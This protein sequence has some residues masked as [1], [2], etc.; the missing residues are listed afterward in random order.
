MWYALNMIKRQAKD[1]LKEYS[2]EFSVVYVNGPRQS[3]KTTLVRQVFPK[4]PYVLLED[5]DTRDIA[6]SDPR[7]FLERYPQG[8]IFDE[9]QECPQLLSYMLGIVD[10]KKKKG[11]F[12][13]T[14]SQNILMLD[15]VKQSLAGRMAILD[16]LPL[17]L[18]ELKSRIRGLSVKELIYRGGYPRIWNEKV[19]PSLQM[20]QYVKTYIERDVRE[21]VNV[22]SLSLFRKFLILCAGRVGYPINKTSICNDLGV[23]DVTVQE[24]LSVLEASN[25]IFMLQ[26]YYENINKRILKTPKLYFVDTAL[27]C[28]L[29][30][31]NQASQVASHPHYGNLFENLIISEF[32]KQSVLDAAHMHS[33]YFF[34]DKSGNEVDLIQEIGNNLQVIE[35]KAGATFNHNWLKGITYLEGS[36]KSKVLTKYIIFTGKESSKIKDISIL[37]YASIDKLSSFS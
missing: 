19:N 14:G 6:I 17:S 20:A 10:R 5:L 3:G 23:S 34:R 2:K 32:K 15:K 9:I 30:G 27:A 22:R 28:Y 37:P 12:I 13:L 11:M 29:L 24:W 35:I 8:A 31:I 1:K 7:G 18:H 33:L 21:I 25:L 26:P 16:L 4:K 36:F